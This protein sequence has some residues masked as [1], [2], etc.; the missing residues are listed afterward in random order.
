MVGFTAR[1]LGRDLRAS[2]E[3]EDARW[4]SRA[5]VRDART[6]GFF[7]PGRFSLA[8]QLIEAFLAEP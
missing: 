2:D 4:F 6:H 1:A 5:Q 7:V 8:G 3:L